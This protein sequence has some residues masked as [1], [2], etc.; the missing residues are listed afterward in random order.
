MY[1]SNNTYKLSDCIKSVFREKKLER[2]YLQ[3]KIKNNWE[4]WLG[5]TIAIRTKSINIWNHKLVIN[6]M[7]APLKQELSY[8]KDTIKQIINKELG[9]NFIQEVEIR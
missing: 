3:V 8:A 2:Q 6:V 1:L 5:R 4:K 7:S 9:E